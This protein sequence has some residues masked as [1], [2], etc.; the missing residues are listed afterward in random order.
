MKKWIVET[1]DYEMNEPEDSTETLSKADPVK[2]LERRYNFV[3]FM[4]F[5]ISSLALSMEGVIMNL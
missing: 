2:N 4:L 1:F 3:L 5:G